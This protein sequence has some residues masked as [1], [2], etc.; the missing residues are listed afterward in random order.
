MEDA[1][2]AADTVGVL[3]PEPASATAAES[4]PAPIPDAALPVAVALA[5]R[6][7]GAGAVLDAMLEV[8]EAPTTL[9]L[10]A[11]GAVPDAGLVPDA[12]PDEDWSSAASSLAAGELPG[13]VDPPDPTA[14][15]PFGI[16]PRCPT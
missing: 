8:D 6:G 10:P 1:G 13:A 11:A 9:V 14:E 3:D 12:A 4:A 5:G 7:P 16:P 15:V 2:D